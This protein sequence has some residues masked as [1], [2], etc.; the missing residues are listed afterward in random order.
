MGMWET[1]SK[2]PKLDRL[3]PL[4]FAE[5][6][7]SHPVDGRSR[8]CRARDG[9]E[10]TDGTRV[11][12]CVWVVDTFET[13]RVFH[14]WELAH[15]YDQGIHSG[16]PKERTGATE[17]M[18]LVEDRLRLGQRTPE[19]VPVVAGCWNDWEIWRKKPKGL[20]DKAEQAERHSR[21]WDAALRRAGAPELDW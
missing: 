14:D 2:P 13:R 15:D 12:G 17:E 3:E 18:D 19:D 6:T 1:T 7:A 8:I 9:M 21:R 5:C 16:L 20:G 4:P 10:L 11:R